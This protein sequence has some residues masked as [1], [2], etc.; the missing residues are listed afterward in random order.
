MTAEIVY[1]H[2]LNNKIRTYLR[3]EHL[4]TQLSAL[5]QQGGEAQQLSFF[6]TLF[7]LIDV[8]DRSDIKPDLLKD[9]ER[10]ES[11]LVLWSRHPSVSDQKLQP[12]LQQ[13]LRF[14]T[15]LLRAGK[16]AQALKE[17]KFLAPLRQRFALPGGCCYFDVPQLQYWLSLPEAEQRQQF[18]DWL[19]QLALTEQAL[20]FVLNFIRQRGE[21]TQIEAENGFFQQNAEQFE[22]LRI[23][24]THAC[25]SFPTVS[26]N[27]YRYAIRFMQLSEQDGRSAC[28]ESVQ[29]QLAC[30]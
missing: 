19:A 24:Y 29:F 16:L 21:F 8:L 25:C 2:P 30:C 4:F 13:A 1:E 10:C 6:T 11:Q 26:G 20:A 22:L 17:D 15:E 27:R 12:L 18:N 23:K 7:A 9:L 28:A 3:I 14:Q 5:G